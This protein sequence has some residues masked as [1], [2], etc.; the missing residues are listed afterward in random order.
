MYIIKDETI[1]LIK[2]KYKISYIVKKSG[3]TRQYIHLIVNRKRKC[4]FDVANKISLALDTNKSII[5]FF[6][7]I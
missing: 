7:K 4:S 1:E 2:E 5:D 3:V 6:D